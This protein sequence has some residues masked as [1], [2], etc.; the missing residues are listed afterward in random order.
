MDAEAERRWP[1][2]RTLYVY[3]YIDGHLL[4][5]FKLNTI[6]LLSKPFQIDHFTAKVEELLRSP[7]KTV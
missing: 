1:H 2:L 4:K 5:G 3:G 7:E 6:A